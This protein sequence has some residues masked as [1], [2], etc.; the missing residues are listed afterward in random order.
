MDLC[1]VCFSEPYIIGGQP[2]DDRIYVE[3]RI[4]RAPDYTEG[5]I[6]CACT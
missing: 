5:E 6:Q 3:N 2:E 4:E 1:Y